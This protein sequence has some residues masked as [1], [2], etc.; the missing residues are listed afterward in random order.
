[1]TYEWPDVPKNEPEPYPLDGICEERE[2]ETELEE[3]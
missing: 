3:S 2:D 1:M